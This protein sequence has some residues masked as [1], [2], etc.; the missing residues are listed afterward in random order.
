M[1]P[2]W[3]ADFQRR[4]HCRT[5]AFIAR[6]FERKQDEA[7]P[8]QTAGLLVPMERR[9]RGARPLQLRAHAEDLIGEWLA[10][11]LSTRDKMDDGD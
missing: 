1:Q 8:P 11:H 2:P 10:S 7:N 3:R 5:T 6:H 9:N 4:G